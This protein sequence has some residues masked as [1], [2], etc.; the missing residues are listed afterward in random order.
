M[1]II[2]NGQNRSVE[3]AAG[4]SLLQLLRNELG[5]RSMKDGCAPE[6]MC[7]ACTVIVDGRPVVSCAQPAERFE[8]KQIET[9][10]GLPEET[11]DLWADAFSATGASQCGYCTPGIVMKS[12][13]LLRREAD[14]GREVI[15]KALAGNLCRCTGYLAIVD[16]IEQVAAAR[17]GG[18]RPVPHSGAA[19]GDPAPKYRSREQVLGMQEYVADHVVPGMLHGALRFSDH[20]RAVV[21]AIDTSAAEAAPGVI[22]VV[23]AADVRGV[24]NQGLIKDDWYQLIAVGETTHYVGDVIAAVAAETRA[25]ARAAAELIVIE[26]EVLEPVTDPFEAMAE[27]APEIAPGGNVLSESAYTRGD[28][29]AALAG[30]AHVVSDSFRTAG[31][32]HAYLEPES[33]LAVPQDGSGPRLHV[34][35]QGQ[36]AWEDRRQIASLLGWPE[37]DVLV[38]QVATGGAFGGKED[39]NVQGHAALLAL[40]AERPVLLALSRADSLRFSVKRHRFWMEYTVGCDAEGHLTAVKA[41]FIGDNGGYAS[42]GTKVLE[43][44]AGHAC[45]AYKVPNVDVKA[46][47]ILT[48]NPPCGAMRGFG[49][50]QANFGMETMLDRLAELVGIDGWEIR[51]RN[52]LAEGD[53][54]G[55]GQRL[56][57]GVGLKETLLAVRDQYRGAKYAG[58]A[59]GAKNTGIGNGMKEYGRAVVRPEGDGRLTVF[60]SWTE[61]G[62]GTHTVMRQIAGDELDLQPDQITVLVDTSH[63]LDTGITTASR[64]TMLGGRAVLKACEALRAEMVRR[65]CRLDDLA[66]EEFPAE[67]V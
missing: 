28:V 51:W 44:A 36:G 63:E 5:L 24:R 31:I 1:D 21:K 64:A 50:N 27:G 46:N 10:E 12:E 53:R 15:T 8:G 32:E 23:T 59:C 42:V 67:I 58:I 41:R 18:P 6:G 54:F 57:P 56:G 65:R 47:A 60:H 30:S 17:A 20:P 45:S 40:K 39:L 35:S 16:A 26:Y 38:T 34:L 62:Q 9:L 7:G 19:V 33:S 55:T 22:A 52:A 66:G 3:F 14:P 29:E 13:A 43:R 37:E 48:N 4:T 11:R 2:L 61:M 49:A 25:Q